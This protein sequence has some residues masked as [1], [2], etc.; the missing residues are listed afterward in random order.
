VTR[1][2]GMACR[3]LLGVES[4]DGG[5]LPEGRPP[6]GEDATGLPEGGG[7]G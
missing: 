1:L 4:N 7:G 2:G 3:A 6:W 5:Q